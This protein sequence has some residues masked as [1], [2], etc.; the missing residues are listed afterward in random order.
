[1][2]YVIHCRAC[3]QYGY[4][5]RAS[6]KEYN[7]IRKPELLKIMPCSECENGKGN[8]EVWELKFR[9]ITALNERF[10]NKKVVYTRFSWDELMKHTD[11]DKGPWVKDEP[12]VKKEV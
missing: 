5:F 1:M 4:R 12:R 3:G 2:G 9:E 10:P 6:Q 11:Q 7:L 8:Q